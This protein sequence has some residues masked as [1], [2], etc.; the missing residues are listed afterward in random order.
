MPYNA[1]TNWRNNDIVTPDDLNRIEKGIAESASPD[2][3]ISFYVSPSGDDT[4]GTGEQ[5]NPFKSIQKAIDSFPSNNALGKSYTIELEEGNYTGFRLAAFKAITINVSG[6]VSITG[7]VTISE[8]RLTFMG[9]AEASVT[10]V[11]GRIA[12]GGGDL[13]AMISLGVTYTDIVS[14]ANAIDCSSGAKFTSTSDVIVA[15]FKTAVRC[16][17]SHIHLKRL[18]TD[19]ITTGIVC[20][21]G[22]VQI[23]D[24]VIQASTKFITQQ[25]GR[26]Y[27]GSQ[28]NMPN[29]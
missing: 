23:G 3:S 14:T 25:G 11:N 27:V 28:T 18:L 7:N 16:A 26:I 4:A 24:D 5:G 21:C 22:I 2:A 12:M 9:D 10:V 19:V 8:G 17:Y 13:T 29:Y 6:Q 1:R 15:N 20:E